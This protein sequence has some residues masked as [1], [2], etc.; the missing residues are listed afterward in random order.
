MNAGDNPLKLLGAV[1]PMLL[2]GIAAFSQSPAPT[3]LQSGTS[4]AA[5][6][7][8]PAMGAWS[9]S[10]GWGDPSSSN[11]T[12]PTVKDLDKMRKLQMG[13]WSDQRVPYTFTNDT[14]GKMF[15]DA[16]TQRQMEINYKL[17]KARRIALNKR[18][19]SLVIPKLKLSEATF[20]TAVEY[21]RQRA[22]ISSG[23]GSHMNIVMLVPTEVCQS[24]K[25]SLDLENIP[26]LDA[27]HYVCDQGNA[28][29]TIQTYA[30]EITDR[31]QTPPVHNPL[32]IPVT[33]QP[34]SE[35][36][37]SKVALKEA[38]L[39]EAL[40]FLKQ[41][42]R[43]RLGSTGTVNFVIHLPEQAVTKTISLNL[44][45]IPFLEALRYVCDQANID[46]S[47]EPF[48]IV[49]T[50]KK[51]P[52]LDRVAIASASPKISSF[53]IPQINLHEVAL[54]DALLLL[55]QRLAKA[56]GGT[57]N[58]NFVE[59]IPEDAQSTPV[60]LDLVNIPFL[61]ALRYICYQADAKY[62]VQQYAIMISR[63]GN[64]WRGQGSVPAYMQDAY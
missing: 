12:D 32:S 58:V 2:A 39:S 24:R 22:E 25:I 21:L 17:E 1:A 27:L 52:L 14:S 51:M 15:S 64:K 60:T 29:F 56:S 44:A 36:F 19:Q 45:A 54:S 30:I 61:E 48:G 10:F 53:V 35:L 63:A 42:G 37:L 28:D 41:Q 26:F 7:N 47:V 8:Q 13:E 50:G 18:F 59:Q 40:D 3:P 5:P 33:Q 34:L 6:S 16:E 55:K 23:T 46:F 57:T 4:S 31:G 11:F 62:S 38:A 20:D 49:V 9:D 43:K